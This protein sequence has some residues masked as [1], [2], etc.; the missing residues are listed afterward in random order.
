MTR[1]KGPDKEPENV[2]LLGLASTL[3]RLAST[4][5]RF[6]VLAKPLDFT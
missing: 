3:V 2:S 4:L 6:G 1:T 5:V